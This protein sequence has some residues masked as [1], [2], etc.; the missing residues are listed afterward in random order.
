MLNCRQASQL[1]SRAMDE[2]LQN[3]I[4]ITAYSGFTS[5]ATLSSQY[6]RDLIKQL[7]MVL[8]ESPDFHR[9]DTP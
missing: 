6:T 1:A 3:K 8:I 7:D 4:I 2:I 9:N 5:S